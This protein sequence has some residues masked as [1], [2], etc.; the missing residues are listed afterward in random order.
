MSTDKKTIDWYN[1]NAH[2]YTAHL[3]NQTDSVYH[4]YYE[5]PAMYSL[6]PDIKEKHV[7]SLGCG[8]GEDSKYLKSFGAKKSIGIDISKNLIK[9][10]QINHPE[11]EFY[12]MNMEQ[13][14]FTNDSFDFVYSSL[15][16]HYIEDWTIV[17]QEVFR[18]LKPN[19]YFL[20]SCQ[21]PIISAMMSEK[22]DENKSNKLIG[23][24]KNDGK[25]SI[26]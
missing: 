7:L 21:H 23:V 26:V 1:Q 4:A 2:I 13:L 25:Q 24:Y 9:I 18:V 10:A 15:A 5:K 22:I 19:T 14:D 20:F 16:L 17:F 6:V 3:Q 8:S 11:C 12:E